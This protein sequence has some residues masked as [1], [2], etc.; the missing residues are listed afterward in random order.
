MGGNEEKSRKASA[1]KNK[2][3]TKSTQVAVASWTILLQ[4]SLAFAAEKEGGG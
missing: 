3:L 1:E 4:D 2:F